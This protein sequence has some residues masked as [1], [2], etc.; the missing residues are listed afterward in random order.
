MKQ[1]PEMVFAFVFLALTNRVMGFLG[2]SWNSSPSHFQENYRK[3]W[4]FRE[5][6]YDWLWTVEQMFLRRRSDVDYG[7]SAKMKEFKHKNL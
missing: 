6:E 7:V 3:S 4:C 1:T 5:R 2:Y